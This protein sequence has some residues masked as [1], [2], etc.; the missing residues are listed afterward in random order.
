M[1]YIVVT[2]TT[3]TLYFISQSFYPVFLL[4]VVFIFVL[5]LRGLYY[6]QF[7][8][9]NLCYITLFLISTAPAK[10]SN[11]K[12]FRFNVYSDFNG[13]SSFNL[14]FIWEIKILAFMTVLTKI[15]ACN[16]YQ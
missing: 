3:C 10:F 5:S 8:F 12:T 14:N 16:K 11:F 1:Y 13:L 7:V 15:C 6:D 2:I 4:H 9:D